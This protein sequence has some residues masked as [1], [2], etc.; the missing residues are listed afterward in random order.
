[1]PRCVRSSLSSLPLP[2]PKHHRRGHIRSLS[3]AAGQAATAADAPAAARPP[4]SPAARQHVP[5]Q[6]DQSSLQVPPPSEVSYWAKEFHAIHERGEADKVKAHAWVALSLLPILRATEIAMVANHAA[7]VKF[8]DRRWWSEFCDKTAPYLVDADAWDIALIFNALA[9]A[10]YRHEKLL[11]LLT[12]ESIAMADRAS[13]RDIAHTLNA[14]SR[15]RYFPDHLFD[16]LIARAKL[17]FDQLN[18]I[19]VVNIGNACGRAN[20]LDIEFA[21]VIARRIEQVAPDLTQQQVAMT[22]FAYDRWGVKDVRLLDAL[23]ERFKTF[24]DRGEASVNFFPSVLSA[25]G[26]LHHKNSTMVALCE[27]HLPTMCKDMI[28]TDVSICMTALARLKVTTPPSLIEALM[29]QVKV[30]LDRDALIPRS[31]CNIATAA[32]VLQTDH[33]TDV[34]AALASTIQAKL[35][36]F[37]GEDVAQILLATAR[38]KSEPKWRKGLFLKAAD[39]VRKRLGGGSFSP[40]AVSQIATAYAAVDHPDTRLLTALSVFARRHVKGYNAHDAADVLKAFAHFD[41]PDR[42][43]F[44]AFGLHISRHVDRFTPYQLESVAQAFVKVGLD[45]PHLSNLIASQKR[46]EAEKEGSPWFY[47][48]TEIEPSAD[49]QRL[50]LS[51]MPPRPDSANPK[52]LTTPPA[53][54]PAP[55]AAA[56]AA[57]GTQ[58]PSAAIVSGGHRGGSGS[59][60]G[61]RERRRDRDRQSSRE[62]GRTGQS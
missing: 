47:E 62:G 55:T 50:P 52:Q 31:V 38:L 51:D 24:S 7:K 25:Y 53:S 3:H 22:T 12:Q 45:N 61:N 32:S 42:Q 46:K 40:R 58:R 56:A 59:G 41:L 16:T 30:L 26:K 2:P 48:A 20:F 5:Q 57:G 10:E 9:Q 49:E 17:I 44:E 18:T 27:Q 1:M 43:L 29:R 15:L 36:T 35:D 39:L 23:A 11:D 19:D 14:C 28:P 4:N 21:D 37:T 54:A 34:W 8:G 60:K 6:E 13:G 33:M